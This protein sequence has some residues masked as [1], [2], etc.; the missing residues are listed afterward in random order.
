MRHFL[1]GGGVG[2][3]AFVLR[4]RLEY[5]LH[6]AIH[7]LADFTT[8]PELAARINKDE[9]VPLL[10]EIFT[11][12]RNDVTAVSSSSSSF[13]SS[14]SPSWLAS[15]SLS[16]SSSS[17]SS[18]FAS[19]DQS[20]SSSSSS[21]FASSSSSSSLLSSSS[22]SS[23]SSSVRLVYPTAMREFAI[24]T[25][26]NLIS[27]DSSVSALLLRLNGLFVFQEGETAI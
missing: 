13:S 4:N 23:S 8:D 9:L 3:I 5:L 20:S 27:A 6:L 7:L 18:S 22:S 14:S 11:G 19:L 1:S 16:S 17:S 10:L 12:V 25:L 26:C 2:V 21:S 24:H 15:S